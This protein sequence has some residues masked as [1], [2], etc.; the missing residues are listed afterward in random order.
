MRY[1]IYLLIFLVFIAGC[2][3]A[4]NKYFT[5]TINYN[6]TYKSDTLN[7]DSLTAI[8]PSK[9]YFRYDTSGYQSRFTGADTNTYYYSGIN[10]KCLSAEGNDTVYTC[11]D[12]SFATDSVMTFKIYNAD[13]KILGYSCMVIEMQKKRSLVKYYYSNKLV[14]APMTYNKHHA[15][16]WDFYGSKTGGGL[17]LKVE[18]QFK[19]FT[20]TGVATNVNKELEEFRAL[21]VDEEKFSEYCK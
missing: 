4:S 21:E 6:Y 17:V 20:M 11:D 14:M 1:F 3:N 15:Y 19:D 7:A 9:G 10:N 2:K 12:Y 8:R 18:H 16:N 5:G 13:E